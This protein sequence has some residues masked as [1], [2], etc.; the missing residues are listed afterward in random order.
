MLFVC[1]TLAF[2][3][4]PAAAYELASGSSGRWSTTASG[5]TGSL[6]SPATLTW[7]IVDDGINIPSV[8]LGSGS[9]VPAGPSG[10]VTYLDSKFGA[11]PGGDDFTQRPWFSHFEDSFNRLG[12]L[13]GLTYVY[14][15][16]GSNPGGLSSSNSGD[17]SGSNARGDVR[18]AGNSFGSGLSGTL[19]YNSFPNYGEMVFNTDVNTFAN[20]SANNYRYFRN[21]IMHEAMHGVGVEH[22]ESSN[23]SFLIE[24]FI[25]TTFDG[26]QLD[27]V[28]ALQRNYGDA[29]EKNGGNDSSLN[30]FDIGTVNTSS[31]AAIGTGGTGTAIG[32]NETDFVSIDDNSDIDFFS[33]SVTESTNVTLDLTPRGALYQIGPQGGSQSNFDSRALSNLTLTLFNSNGT[34]Q[35][36]QSSS[37]AAGGIESITSGLDSGDYLARVTGSS[38]D[39]QLYQLSIFASRDPLDLV[40]T[41]QTSS[42]WSSGGDMNFSSTSGSVAFVN[43]DNVRF[44]DTAPLNRR[45]VTITD[46]NNANEIVFDA[47]GDYTLQG[48]GAITGGSVRVD[49]T[50]TVTIDNDGNS[51]AGSTQVNSGTLKLTGDLSAMQ[52]DFTIADGATLVMNASDTGAMSSSFLIQA[53]GEL[54]VGESG[55]VTNASTFPDNPISLVNNGTLRVF[56]FEAVRNI[57]G[58]GTVIA[59]ELTSFFGGGSDYTGQTIVRSGA[60]AVAEDGTALGSAQGDTV[61]ERGGKLQVQ[62]VATLADDITFSSTG[63]GTSILQVEL[64]NVANFTGDISVDSSPVTIQADSSAIINFFGNFSSTGGSG[65][66]QFNTVGTV[67]VNGPLQL[68]SDGLQKIAVG[69]LNINASLSSS[70][71]LQLEDGTTML[72][73]SGNITGIVEVG[74]AANLN[75]S[76]SYVWHG[77][78]TLAGSGTV[79]GDLTIGGSVAPGDSS[80]ADSIGTLTLSD[81]LALTSTSTLAF[82]IGGTNPGQ[83][84]QLLIDGT[85]QIDG[86]LSVEFIDLGGG[87]YVPELGDS[88]PLLSVQGG[89]GGDYDVLDLPE[90]DA[91]LEW[92]LNS[93]GVVIALDVVAASSLTAD[94]NT[95]GNVDAA[96]L[97]QWQGDFGINGESDA[98]QDGLSTGLDFLTWQQQRAGSTPSSASNSTIPEPSTALLVIFATLFPC[99][100]RLSRAVNS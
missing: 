17:L 67:N 52:S 35:L 63:S 38:N 59:E 57:S 28:L 71:P 76:G 62:A 48:T 49:G 31:S 23:A 7:S 22:I 44:D 4:A 89:A 16:E 21:T 65:Q 43:G 73:G 32:A 56:D 10:L 86:T 58:S 27:D 55:F 79:A 92:Q 53:G 82:E 3:H 29:L 15:V 41:G 99:R 83:F 36:G 98:N 12:E 69:N 40:W 14:Q 25:A 61:V 18:I 90:L 68:G 45:T 85:A 13:S 1:A 33:F 66:V 8:N 2:A 54:H 19:A 81:D 87:V 24:P 97:N 37:A 84:D 39:V 74:P 93:V 70:G 96:D 11:G 50:G 5:N 77:T 9:S 64:G 47:S 34:V 30:A 80:L 88:F 6:G 51:Y 95:D 100:L 94:F 42:D 26:P 46:Q 60:I 91:G 78:S 75:L 20:S 72:A